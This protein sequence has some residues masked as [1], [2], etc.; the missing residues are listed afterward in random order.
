MCEGLN[1][2]VLINRLRVEPQALLDGKANVNNM[3]RFG[4]TAL[5]NATWSHTDEAIVYEGMKVRV[6]FLCCP[7]LLPHY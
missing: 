7:Y 5:M 3:D 4:R 2:E 1:R 6:L